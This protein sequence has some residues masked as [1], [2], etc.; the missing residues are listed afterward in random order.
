ML[1]Y[2]QRLLKSCLEKD[3]RKRLRDIGDAWRLLD[4]PSQAEGR[5][6]TLPWALAIVF[7]II[8]ITIGGVAWRAASP[9][10]QPIV[11]YGIVKDHG[12]TIMDFPPKR[13]LSNIIATLFRARI[14][15]AD[16]YMYRVKNTKRS[17]AK[18]W[19][20]LENLIA[21]AARHACSQ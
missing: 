2:A 5:H 17:T 3:P 9:R 10:T 20:E 13:G 14:S 7:A 12:H 4:E 8:A 6:G 15:R 19:K 1:G 18:H 21:D 11:Q 16:E